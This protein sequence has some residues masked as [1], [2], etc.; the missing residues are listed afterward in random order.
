METAQTLESLFSHQLQIEQAAVKLLADARA[1]KTVLKRQPLSPEASELLA[2]LRRGGDTAKTLATR[3]S[4]A[5]LEHADA[6]HVAEQSNRPKWKPSRSCS[7]GQRARR[8]MLKNGGLIG[9][10]DAP[11]FGL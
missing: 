5:L 8:D 11:G 9:N 10:I 1:L 3:F 6:E 2:E 7:A 4:S